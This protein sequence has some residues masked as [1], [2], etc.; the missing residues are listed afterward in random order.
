MAGGWGGGGGCEVRMSKRRS[1][2]YS[3]AWDILRYRY[4]E[5]DYNSGMIVG[6]G[7]SGVWVATYYMFGYNVVFTSRYI[8]IKNLSFID[9]TNHGSI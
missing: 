8:T 1:G 9:L 6:D 2:N 7:L 5:I 3:V 4:Q